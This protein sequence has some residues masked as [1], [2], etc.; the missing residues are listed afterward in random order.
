MEMITTSSRYQ[1]LLLIA[2]TRKT[3]SV[4]FVLL[5]LNKTNGKWNK[6]N[7]CAQ[8]HKEMGLFDNNNNDCNYFNIDSVATLVG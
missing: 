6:I 1:R 5:M 3:F 4:F 2:Y 7:P 8:V